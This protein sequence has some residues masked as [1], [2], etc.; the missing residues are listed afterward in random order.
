MGIAWVR[1]WY[2][3][4]DALLV[5]LELLALG[6]SG[7]ILTTYGELAEATGL[8][9]KQVRRNMDVLKIE[10]AISVSRAFRKLRITI[11]NVYDI[12]DSLDN[13]EGKGQLEGIY[14]QRA[15][16]RNDSG[17]QA[18]LPKVPK[19]RA[20]RTTEDKL[21]KKRG[22][23]WIDP[24]PDEMQRHFDK[25]GKELVLRELPRCLDWCRDKGT[26]SKD[27]EA[28]RRNWFRKAAEF[29]AEKGQG[30]RTKYEKT[31]SK[32]RALDT[33]AEGDDNEEEGNSGL[34]SHNQRGL[35][36]KF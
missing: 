24:T 7:P 33:W 32:I 11:L 8:T 30:A 3:K 36:I 13:F 5:L 25:F 26:L 10:Q 21:L 29:L 16:Y 22:S 34:L 35:P 17:N 23:Q 4:P 15:V 18:D 20:I 28:R 14:K 9:L 1:A 31:Q 2:G 19:K 27:W 6:E 12:P